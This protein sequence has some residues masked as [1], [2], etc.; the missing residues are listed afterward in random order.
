MTFTVEIAG[1][2]RSIDVRRS[3]NRWIVTID[4]HATEVDAQR[5][6]ERWS[7]LRGVSSNEVAVDDR[8]NGELTV[9]VDGVAVPVAIARPRTSRSRHGREGAHGGGPVSVSAP[10]PGRIV[11]VL[12]KP[13]ESVAPRQGLI[14]VE[15]MKMENEL[16][17]P[18]AA[19]V[20]RVHVAPGSAVEKGAMLLEMEADHE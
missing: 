2:R 11:K 14:V 1:S 19:R 18:A 9:H 6:G 5:L 3:G 13:G 4:G 16:R 8:G 10:M 20:K 15:A 17:A 7:L 12:V